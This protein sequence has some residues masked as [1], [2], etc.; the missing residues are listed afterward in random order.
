MGVKTHSQFRIPNVGYRRNHKL[1]AAR[2]NAPSSQTKSQCG[3]HEAR[4]VHASIEPETQN[5]H[6]SKAVRAIGGSQSASLPQPK[7]AVTARTEGRNDD[8]LLALSLFFSKTLKIYKVHR[9]Q[10][11]KSG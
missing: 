10:Y 7:V 6:H 11:R 5:P 3:F 9:K 8:A 2:F 4:Y 1:R